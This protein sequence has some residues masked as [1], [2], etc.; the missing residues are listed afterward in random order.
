M[1][2]VTYE[3][4]VPDFCPEHCDRFSPFGREVSVGDGSGLVC[5]H[6]ECCEILWRQLQKIREAREREDPEADTEERD[7]V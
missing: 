1:K 2:K 4:W 3:F 5:L 6:R 7:G